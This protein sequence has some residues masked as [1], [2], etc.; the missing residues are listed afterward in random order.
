MARS[1]SRG[2]RGLSL[3]WSALFGGAALGWG[4]FALLALLGVALGLSLVQGGVTFGVISAGVAAFA[5]GW[6]AVRLTGDRRRSAGLTH[7]AVSWAISMAAGA[8]LALRFVWPG[9]Q[10]RALAFAGLCTGLLGLGAA[11]LG[12]L[13]A[14][15][16]RATDRASRGVGWPARPSAPD[17][18]PDVRRDETTIIPPLH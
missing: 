8:M 6:F 13:Y 15:S 7:G 3:D 18:L 14:A 17:S 2:S 5:G 11:L 12:A 4:V 1:E 16:R 9:T 10:I